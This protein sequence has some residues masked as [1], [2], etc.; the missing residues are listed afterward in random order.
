M[1]LRLFVIPSFQYLMFNMLLKT[2]MISGSIMTIFLFF[3]LFFTFVRSL[4]TTNL[5]MT[6]YLTINLPTY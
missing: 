3:R 4:C 1:D 6:K 2:V 5:Q